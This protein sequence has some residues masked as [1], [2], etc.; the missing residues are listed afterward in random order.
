MIR[1]IHS[2]FYCLYATFGQ[3][4]SIK[5]FLC[6]YRLW[7]FKV[8]QTYFRHNTF[9]TL[10]NGH[11]KRIQKRGSKKVNNIYVEKNFRQ[12]FHCFQSFCRYSSKFHQT[13]F[14]QTIHI[15]IC[16][17]HSLFL[18]FVFTCLLVCLFFCLIVCVV[19]LSLLPCHESLFLCICT[20][21]C[22]YGLPFSRKF[23]L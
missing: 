11:L 2:F 21:L 22:S 15:N 12:T 13:L 14:H 3:Q 17:L 23:L 9:A 8:C 19:M 18:L 5:Y 4:N 20:Y 7:N 10:S 16:L 1:E 6:T